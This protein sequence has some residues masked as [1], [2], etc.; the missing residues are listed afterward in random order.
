MLEEDSVFYN[1]FCKN[2]EKIIY[3]DTRT[4]SSDSSILTDKFLLTALHPCLNFVRRM[5]TH[6]DKEFF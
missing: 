3:C 2:T 6:F 5:F 4:T 1:V